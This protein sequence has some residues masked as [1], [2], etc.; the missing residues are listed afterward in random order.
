MQD[1]SAETFCFCFCFFFS[2]KNDCGPFQY[3]NISKVKLRYYKTELE[4]H[5]IG[6]VHFCWKWTT[7]NSKLIAALYIHVE[8]TH[9]FISR[10]ISK[11][12][13]KHFQQKNT[14]EKVLKQ[15][16]T[17]F[18]QVVFLMRFYSFNVLFVNGYFI[19]MHTIKICNDT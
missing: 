9:N 10:Y 17:F 5:F 4:R 7:G 16:I 8:Y 2:N 12:S 6:H 15:N 19:S 13:I 14:W 3:L 1:F 11:I 18:L